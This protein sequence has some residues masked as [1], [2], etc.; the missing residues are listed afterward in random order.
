MPTGSRKER[1]KE[2]FKN[3]VIQVA[4]SLVKEAGLAGLTLRKLAKRLEYSTTKL[5]HEFGAK[6]ALLVL[7][8]EDICQ[9]QNE[10]LEALKK[11]PDPEEHLLFVTREAMKFY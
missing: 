6:N 1:E 4:Y 5:Y 11:L 10:R 8:G 3:D 2:R 9:R 7:L